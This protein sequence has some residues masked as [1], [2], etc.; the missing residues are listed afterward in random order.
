LEAEYGLVDT[1][2]ASFQIRHL[3]EQ[4]SLDIKKALKFLGQ[5]TAYVKD[6]KPIDEIGNIL[7]HAKE[8]VSRQDLH[9]SAIE[10]L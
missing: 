7:I 1:K 2:E 3:S 5:L 4:V 9:L 8:K 10:R 6:T